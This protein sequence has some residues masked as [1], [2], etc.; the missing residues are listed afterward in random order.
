MV[1]ILDKKIENI[2]SFKN[3][4]WGLIFLTKNKQLFINNILIEV[5]LDSFSIVD[6][7]IY[8]RKVNQKLFYNIDNNKTEQFNDDIPNS[9][10]Q[11][12]SC[13]PKP[14]PN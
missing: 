9:D 7:R 2:D 10:L 14:L 13:S 4:S 8:F 12:V 6:N 11:N 1:Y 5:G 3:V